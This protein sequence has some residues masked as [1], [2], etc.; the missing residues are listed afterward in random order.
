MVWV[1]DALHGGFS[2]EK[3]WLPVA[4]DHLPLAVTAQEANADSTLHFFRRM[5]AWRKAHP[6]LW[7]GSFALH[8][9]GEAFL[10]FRRAH[11]GEEMVCAF[12]L[13]ADPARVGLP[14]GE[15][16]V[17]EG[18]GFDARIEGPVAQLPPYQALFAR[19]V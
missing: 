5:L 6:V 17:V 12:N 13:G 7:K 2:D 9:A 8:G 18:T 19:R 3:P 15:W 10:V 11:A 14:D 4:I 16:R 1:S